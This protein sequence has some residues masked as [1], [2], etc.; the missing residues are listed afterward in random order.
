MIISLGAYLAIPLN[1][2]IDMTGGIQAEYDYAGGQI[3]IDSVQSIVEEVK[4]GINYNGAEVINNINVYKIAGE[5]KFVI[6]AGFSKA[7]GISDK[8][9]E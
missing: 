4:K 8:D 5:D 9:F 7:S 3:Q 6:E 1:L 2:G